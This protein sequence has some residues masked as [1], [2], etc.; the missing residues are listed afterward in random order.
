MILD[1]TR[2]A[3]ISSLLSDASSLINLKPFRFNLRLGSTDFFIGRQKRDD[4]FWVRDPL[5]QLGNVLETCGFEL[6][7]NSHDLFSAAVC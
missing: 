4:S 3:S 7:F 5:E 2:S 6:Y 1:L